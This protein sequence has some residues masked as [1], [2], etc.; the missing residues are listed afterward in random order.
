MII[1][2]SFCNLCVPYFITTVIPRTFFCKTRRFLFMKLFFKVYL[3]LYLIFFIYFSP[4]HLHVQAS[5]LPLTICIKCII[6][7]NILCNSSWIFSPV[8]WS[9]ILV[10]KIEWVYTW[11]IRPSL[12]RSKWKMDEICGL[13]FH[14]SYVDMPQFP[15]FFFKFLHAHTM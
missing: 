9:I 13:Q 8:F 12:T 14:L 7:T 3:S 11:A 5:T 1:R 15:S 4:C 10:R 6:C 2:C